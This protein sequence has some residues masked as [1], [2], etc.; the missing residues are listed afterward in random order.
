MF[1][2]L[3]LSAI[4]RTLS[5][6]R[7][8]TAPRS[9]P[10]P[11]RGATVLGLVTTLLIAMVCFGSR[12][13]GPALAGSAAVPGIPPHFGMGSS[14]LITVNR[15]CRAEA[16][17]AQTM[18]DIYPQS[19]NPGGVALSRPNIAGCRA[20]FELVGSNSE[21]R[22]RG[23][24]SAQVG[25][26]VPIEALAGTT[27]SDARANTMSNPSRAGRE[28]VVP[29]VASGDQG[30]SAYV[31]IRN[32]DSQLPAT[33]LLTLQDATTGRQ[34]GPLTRRIAANGAV[35]VA[36]NGARDRDLLQVPAGFTGAVIVRAD[37]PIAVQVFTEWNGSAFGMAST[38]GVP[39]DLAAATLHAPLVY[40]AGPEGRTWIAVANVGEQPADVL[41]RYRLDGTGCPATALARGG[42]PIRL[43][44]GASTVIDQG[45]PWSPDPNLG[46]SG[47]RP[48]CV[49]SA[50]IVG[51]AQGRLVSTVFAQNRSGSLAGYQT[52]RE[53]D[54]ARQVILPTFLK[55]S[56][57]F[58]L[59]TLV[60]VK[61]LSDQPASVELLVLD[62]GGLPMAA[63]CPE[64][65]VTLAPW[66]STVWSPAQ[67]TSLGM[68]SSR[69]GSAIVRS[70][71]PIGVT[72]AETSGN[73]RSDSAMY[74]GIPSL[75]AD[76]AAVPVQLP[77][78]LINAALDGEPRTW[79]T[80]AIYVPGLERSAFGQ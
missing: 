43:A 9:A 4:R 44:P 63:P 12:Q 72:V 17:P 26:D 38:E 49:G 56:T 37:L 52:L 54:G 77:M 48:G 36:L 19:G 79:T 5:S 45:E 69:A 76:E 51:G 27:W 59:S 11:R 16:R 62:A 78:L 6:R 39:V 20:A 65:R 30:L 10:A 2:P 32:T 74:L 53:G 66:G 80:H 73:N 14:S 75:E 29:W 31:T 71:R 35:T 55:R 25:A 64:C 68:S 47:V 42:T 3:R 28:V 58:D 23:L 57:S 50:E 41:V 33:A 1:T 61:N 7:V 21:L 24:F 70:D 60:A 22:Q 15:D 40:N 34:I 46:P 8:L 18:V 13:P 67:M